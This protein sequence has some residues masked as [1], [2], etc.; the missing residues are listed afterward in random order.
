[1]RYGW[2]YNNRFYVAVLLTV[3]A[4]PAIAGPDPMR[5]AITAPIAPMPVK[6]VIDSSRWRLNLIRHTSDGQ[7]ALINGKLVKRG[8]QV[9]DARVKTIG[10]RQVILI[11][12]DG[13]TLK[14]E[15]PSI[16][17]RNN[18]S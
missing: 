3:F 2:V 4:F 11:L 13:N 17:M 10:K 15:L 9:G 1:M 14:L 6:E 16:Q 5:P 7:V 8:G 18:H 12:A